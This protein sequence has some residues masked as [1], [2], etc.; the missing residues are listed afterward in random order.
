VPERDA[1]V[2]DG[3]RFS[4]RPACPALPC[5]HR[6]A[7]LDAFTGNSFKVMHDDLYTVKVR[8]S[9]A[10]ARWVR[11]GNETAVLTKGAPQR[12]LARLIPQSC[13]PVPVGSSEGWQEKPDPLNRC[14]TG[15]DWNP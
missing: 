10:W 15:M 13:P 3:E 5:P 2:D 14:V 8:I 4:W 1:D 9:P 12:E 7:L 11:G 6:D